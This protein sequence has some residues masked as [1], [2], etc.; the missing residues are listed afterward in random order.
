VAASLM[1]VIPAIDLLQGRAVRLVQGD[2]QRVLD[3]GADPLSLA[4]RFVEQGALR[5]HLV[6]LEGARAGRWMNLKVIQEIASTVPIPIQSGGGA[7]DLDH[8]RPALDCGVDRVIVGTAALESTAEISA[9]AAIL[10]ERF[11]VSLD[12]RAGRLLS[13]G[14][15]EETGQDMVSL[16]RVLADG[17]VARFIHTDVRRDGTLQGVDLA[18]LPALKAVGRPVLVAVGISTHEDITKVR[19]AGAEGVI[20][21]RALLEGRLELRRAL[22]T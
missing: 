22:A 15:M 19:Q 16:A 18:G 3:Y 6:D 5:L 8:A 17:G 9:W 12:G 11:L 2:Y 10:G 13:R 4:Q 14:W 1:E 7:R 21:G 20:I